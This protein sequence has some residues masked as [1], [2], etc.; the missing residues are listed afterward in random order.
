MASSRIK[1]P[2]FFGKDVL[3]LAILAVK[4]RFVEGLGS[5]D[6]GLERPG[7]PGVKPPKSHVSWPC[8]MIFPIKLPKLGDF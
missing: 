2:S 5:G 1:S 3:D 4:L 8:F 7:G 6:L